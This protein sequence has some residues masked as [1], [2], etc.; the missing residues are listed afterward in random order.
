SGKWGY[1]A[2]DGR[3]IAP[4]IYDKGHEF[5]E[6]RAMVVKDSFVGFIDRNGHL[7]ISYHFDIASFDIYSYKRKNG[8]Q[9]GICPVQKN[10]FWGLIDTNGLIVLDFKYEKIT[11]AESY[12]LI[13]GELFPIDQNHA[14]A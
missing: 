10:G 7:T 1:I 3:V 12:R 4:C 2:K 14:L 11:F 6:G 9:N 8:F 5:C 13:L